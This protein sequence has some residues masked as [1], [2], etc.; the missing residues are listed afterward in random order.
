MLVRHASLKFGRG[1]T[2]ITTFC[3]NYLCF[4]PFLGIFSID[5]LYYFHEG[6]FHSNNVCH[7]KREKT[8]SNIS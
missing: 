4:T 3:G 6:I 1:Y 5:K 8:I 7:G 2:F